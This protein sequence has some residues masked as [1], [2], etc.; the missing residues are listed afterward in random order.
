MLKQISIFW[1]MI[2]AI[3]LFFLLFQSRYPRRKTLLISIGA[4][5]PLVAVTLLLSFFLTPAQMGLVLLLTLTLPSLVFFWIIAKNRDGRFFFTF[6]LADTMVL[7]ILYITQI[8]NHYISPDCD[9][10]LLL[11]RLVAFPLLEW[12]VYKK[13]RVTFLQVQA[14]TKKGW[15]NFALIGALFYV[16]MTL[17]MNYPVSPLEQ[18]QLLP[19]V[20]LLFVLIPVIYIH[21]IITLRHQQTLHEV[22]AQ[23]DILRLQ[24]SNLISRTEELSAADGRFRIERHNFRHHLKTLASLVDAGQYAEARA[25]L[26]EYSEVLDSTV[27]ERYCQH[28]VLDAV[29]SSYIRKAWSKEIKVH[30]GLAFPDTLP[31][32]EAELATAFA[33]ALE[34]AINA[35]EKV[36]PDKRYIDIK[37]LNH[38]RFIIQIANSY[39]GGVEFDADEIPVSHQKDHG[40][41]TRS[42]AAFCQKNGGF[43][44]FQADGQRFSLDLNF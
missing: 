10:F 42:I 1:S 19:A 8:L 18:P 32:R 27:V 2:H 36:E 21:I 39:T 29:L 35:C 23:E 37:V 17:M 31:V 43:Y 28:T 14:H 41:G 16:L 33:N 25:L 22:T 30:V 38:P 26:D 11:S 7:E 12:L 40:F 9:L 15:G 44:Q 5:A 3:V 24:V 4:M 20:I 34:N 13:I 6:C